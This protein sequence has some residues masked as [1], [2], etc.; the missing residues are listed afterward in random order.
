MGRD[1]WRPIA[2]RD[3]KI[4]NVLVKSL[5]IKEDWSDVDI[6]LGDFRLSRYHDPIQPN[7]LGSIG[8]K[9]CWLQEVTWEN[10]ALSPASDV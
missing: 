3:I 9:H 1:H 10:K 6:K 7:P 2:H 4:E 8:T 5:G